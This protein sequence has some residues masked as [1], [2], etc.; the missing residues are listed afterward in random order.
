MTI[1]ECFEFF[2]LDVSA[3]LD[4]V[5]KAYRSLAK[6]YHP[7]LHGEASGASKA[8]EASG[9]KMTLVNE[10]YRVLRGEIA[11]RKTRPEPAA[12]SAPPA[13]AKNPEPAP[14]LDYK[15]YKKGVEFYELHYGRFTNFFKHYAV[16]RSGSEPGLG[17]E[18]IL[19]EYAGEEKNLAK[20][21]VC[22]EKLLR[23]F[24]DSD[25]AEDTQERLVKV[26]RTLANVRKRIEDLR[27]G[28][29]YWTVNKSTP[30]LTPYTDFF[31]QWK[32]KNK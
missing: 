14:D 15:L 11:G 24:P 30:N 32:D 4:E 12:K 8:S 28:Q 25:W 3:S 27:T 29:S 13:A 2:G 22:F 10:A 17:F 31:K 6:K 21:K 19:K 26:E 5:K 18:G 9:E 7:D 20:A 16:E 23:D 1:T